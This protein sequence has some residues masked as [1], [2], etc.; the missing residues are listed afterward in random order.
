MM[1]RREP[2]AVGIARCS[3]G[4]G[5]LWTPANETLHFVDID[6]H[7]LHSYVWSSGIHRERSF[8]V[9]VCCIADAGG[10][11]LLIALDTQLSLLSGARMTTVWGGGLPDNVRFNDGKCDPLGRFFIG[12]THRQFE[13]GY[14]CLY[15]LDVQELTLVMDGLG[16]SNGLAWTSDG[17]RMLHIDTLKRHIAIYDYD[18]AAGELVALNDVLDLSHLPG[19]PDGMTIDA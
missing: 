3:L 8:D 7:S 1:E 13:N 16:L 14:G 6:G 5:P 17:E 19:M 2:S 4:E 12:T 10:G 15:R 11:D 9:Q 18:V